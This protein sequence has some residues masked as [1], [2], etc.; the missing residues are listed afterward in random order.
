MLNREK[1]NT[2]YITG[3]KVTPTFA[4]AKEMKVTS[5]ANFIKQKMKF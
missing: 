4:K 3:D 5:P 1:E 2:I